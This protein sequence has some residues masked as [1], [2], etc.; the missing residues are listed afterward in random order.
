M[1]EI[2]IDRS[3]AH[4]SDAT[5]MKHKLHLCPAKGAPASESPSQGEART[6]NNQKTLFKFEIAGETQ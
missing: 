6:R 2:E 4:Y 3:H 1:C 5:V